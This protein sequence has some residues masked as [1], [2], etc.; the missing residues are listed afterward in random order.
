MAMESADKIARTY[1]RI[2]VLQNTVKGFTIVQGEHTFKN[3]VKL[4]SILLISVSMLK[5]F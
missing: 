2:D 4:F 5:N 3:T 1:S